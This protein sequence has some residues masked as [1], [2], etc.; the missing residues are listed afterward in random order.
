V[1]PK[2]VGALRDIKLHVAGGPQRVEVRLTEHAGQVQVAVRTPD[3]HLAGTLRENLPTL[4]ARLAENGYRTEAWHPSAAAAEPRRAA[5]ASQGNLAQ[6]QQ[7]RGR[8]D[9]QQSGED[10][11]RPKVPE[12]PIER[13]QKGKDFAW[14]MS[15]LQ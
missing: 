12:A 11:R 15:T 5:E 7:Q 10:P 4:S 3:S 1:Q 14:L 9:G 13:K 6:D 2:P 8:H